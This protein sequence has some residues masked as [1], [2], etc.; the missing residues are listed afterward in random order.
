[1]KFRVLALIFA[2]LLLPF[3]LALAAPPA[4]G[5]SQAPSAAAESPQ[6]ALSTA[7]PLCLGADFLS[8]LPQAQPDASICGAC[9]DTIC[10]GRAP[11]SVCGSGFRC[12]SQGLCGNVSTA[13]HC[14]CLII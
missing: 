5:T 7:A 10:A 3:S 4:A 13:L 8:F 2:A 14:R 6:S 12:I 9:S 11:N 1:M